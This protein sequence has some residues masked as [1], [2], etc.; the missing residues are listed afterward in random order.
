M[1]AESHS[2]EE[3]TTF[4]QVISKTQV[5]GK[6][7]KVVV[8][9]V[10]VCR[11]NGTMEAPAPPTR[12][13]NSNIKNTSSYPA[14]LAELFRRLSLLVKLGKPLGVDHA[15][16]MGLCDLLDVESFLDLG[17]DLLLLALHP[18]LK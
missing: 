9:K 2:C 17:V 14:D 5:V 13:I 18:L 10:P 6:K 7:T 3:I 16:I 1:H 11:D 8:L 4:L 15:L 12:G